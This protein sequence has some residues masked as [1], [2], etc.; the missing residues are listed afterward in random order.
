MPNTI[1]LRLLPNKNIIAEMDNIPLGNENSYRIIAGEKNSTIF[2]I[3][4]KPT[5]YQDAIYSV[6]MVN[7]Q[8]YGVNLQTIENDTFNLPNIMAVAGYGQISIKCVLG[9]EV[10]NFNPLKIKVWNTIPNWREYIESSGAGLSDISVDTSTGTITKT[11][12]SGDVGVDNG[13][14]QFVKNEINTAIGSAL[15]GEY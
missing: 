6:E 3:K 5:Q 1:S 7:S 11:Y 12:M 15:T 4:S 2:N 9:D 13:L 14:S 10:V 8:G